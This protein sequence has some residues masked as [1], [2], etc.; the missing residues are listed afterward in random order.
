MDDAFLRIDDFARGGQ[1]RIIPDH[2][3]GDIETE[4]GLILIVRGGIDLRADFVIE[5]QSI[6]RERGTQFGLAVLARHHEETGPIASTTR[7]V[8]RE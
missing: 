7:A 1:F 5:Q 3:G 8:G 4:R 2:L 6:N